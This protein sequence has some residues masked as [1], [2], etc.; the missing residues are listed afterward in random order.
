ME[1]Q[2]VSRD[3]VFNNVTIQSM[4]IKETNF[5]RKSW[6]QLMVLILRGFEEIV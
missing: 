5:P 6:T 2:N 1:V 3:C 4:K